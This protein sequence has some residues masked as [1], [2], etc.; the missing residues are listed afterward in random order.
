MSS[1]ADKLDSDRMISFLTQYFK[2]DIKDE[3][4]IGDFTKILNLI[5]KG[6]DKKDLLKIFSLVSKEVKEKMKPYEY[7]SVINE[8]I[9]DYEINTKEVGLLSDTELKIKIGNL[10]FSSLKVTDTTKLPS[11]NGKFQIKIEKS[12]AS[13]PG[14]RKS[15][16]RKSKLNKILE[17]N[18]N[19]ENTTSNLGGVGAATEDYNDRKNSVSEELSPNKRKMSFSSDSKGGD[20]AYTPS[21]LRKS[22]MRID[23]KNEAEA[24]GNKMLAIDGNPLNCND[25][26]VL[27]A[28]VSRSSFI[29]RNKIISY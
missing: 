29:N 3:E 11:M 15:S 21:K 7:S 2:M 20:V 13:R 6:Y 8:I 27:N 18:R 17:K 9:H 24:D 19:V 28:R 4:I 10:D 22:V 26:S 12:S 25:L 16:T 5:Y 14:S 1:I 23:T